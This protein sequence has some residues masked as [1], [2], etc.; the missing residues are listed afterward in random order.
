MLSIGS[1]VKLK[2]TGDRGKVTELLPE[3]MINVYLVDDDMEIPV[4]EDDLI[5]LENVSSAHGKVLSYPDKKAKKAFAPPQPLQAKKEVK[6]EGES[7]GL[8]LVF[9][10]VLNDENTTDRYL[11]WLINDTEE[12]YIFNLLLKVKGEKDWDQNAKLDKMSK[13]EMGTMPFDQ[14]NDNPVFELQKWRITSMGTQDFQKNSIKI[15]PKTFFGKLRTAP[16]I[17]VP[18]HWFLA[19]PKKKKAAQG[20][21]L[22]SYTKRNA[23][24]RLPRNEEERRRFNLNDVSEFASF[25]IEIDLHVGALETD[26]TGMDAAQII[27]VQMEYFD[28]FIENAVRIGVPRVFVIHG[29]GKGKL[30]DLI[31]TRLVNHPDVKTFRN[32][33]HPR[34]GWGATEV[35][36]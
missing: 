32:E 2:F 8:Q 19:F 18:V 28:G 12:E 21:D 17:D 27:R 24:V 15:K 14:L 23:S 20:E 6:F 35:E 11:I 9:E 13:T 25:E 4:H 22:R 16:F 31:A 30:R 33:Y 1:K 7:Q 26:T 29:L 5:P 34:Y 10:P 36:F 3:G